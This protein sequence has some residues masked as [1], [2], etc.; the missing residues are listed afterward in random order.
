MD[1]QLAKDPA[2]IVGCTLNTTPY[3]PSKPPVM[4]EHSD[5]QVPGVT[6]HPKGRLGAAWRHLGHGPC[7]PPPV[8]GEGVSA[9]RASELLR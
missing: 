1:T 4:P 2:K 8:P 5:L 6:T 3:A 9:T 7:I